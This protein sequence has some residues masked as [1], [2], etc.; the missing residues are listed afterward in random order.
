MRLLMMI[1]LV[2][3][4]AAGARA[5][6]PPAAATVQDCLACHGDPDLSITLGSGETQSLHVDAGA[7][8]H[9][10]HGSALNC[11]ACHPGFTEQ[12]HPAVNTAS[13]APSA[14]PFATPARPV[15]STTTGRPTTACITSSWPPTYLADFHGMTASLHEGKSTGRTRFTARCI[16]CHGVHDIKRV[17]EPDSRVIRANLVKTCQACHAPG[18]V[19]AATS[20]PRS[21]R[22]STR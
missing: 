12:P 20:S 16:D 6:D 5:A 13:R 2:L 4:A 9:S 15:I 1:A 18:R 3:T 19:C 10:V 8:A 17:K 22:S 14:P 21:R 7:Y 11:T